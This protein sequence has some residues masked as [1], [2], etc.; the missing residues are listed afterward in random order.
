MRLFCCPMLSGLNRKTVRNTRSL[1]LAFSIFLLGAQSLAVAH[2]HL[3]D[4][5]E[6]FGQLAQAAESSC[7]LCIFHFHTPTSS[8]PAPLIVRPAE[9]PR[10]QTRHSGSRTFIVFASLTFSRAPPL[11]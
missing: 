9:L 6:C 5:Q 7:P 10:L 3:T 8:A 4:F 1:A 11:V 2:F